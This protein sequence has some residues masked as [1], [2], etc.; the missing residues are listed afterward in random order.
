MKNPADF[1]WLF[2]FS[3]SREERGEGEERSMA[4]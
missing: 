3:L 2:F 1:A 4:V